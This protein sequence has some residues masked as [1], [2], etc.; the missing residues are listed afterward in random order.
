[1]PILCLSQ[2]GQDVFVR[3][4]VGRQGTFLDLG[5]FRPTYHNN[6]RILDLEGWSGLSIDYQNFGEE[7]KQ[8]RNTPFLHADVTTIDWTKILEDYPFLKGT[9]DYIS[10][11]VDDATRPAFD[12]FPFDKIK[13]AC[14]T[15]EH[16][17]YRVGTELRDHLRQKLTSLGYVLLCADVVMPDTAT[18]KYGA[19]EDWWVNP[20]LV[21]MDR[22]ESIRSNGI[23]Y[24]EIFK[25]IN[26]EQYA[27]YCPPPS[28][29]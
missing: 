20:E 1:M 3:H 19:F 7:F 22:L 26:P 4:V 27:F 8:K 29:D 16:D 2:A 5:S 21:D 25:K 13:F 10:F 9:I 11:D 28:Y 14:M 23:S 15:I 24:L 18:E 12:R 17:Q 6:T